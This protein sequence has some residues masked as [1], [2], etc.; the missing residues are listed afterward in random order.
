VTPTTSTLMI[1]A[2]T[3]ALI[4]EYTYV[5]GGWFTGVH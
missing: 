3:I 4:R 1:R 5:E 2:R